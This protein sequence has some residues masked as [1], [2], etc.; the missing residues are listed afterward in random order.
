MR[1][2]PENLTKP[3]YRMDTM[4]A[5]VS[6]LR[7]SLQK[8]NIMFQLIEEFSASTLLNN[9]KSTM[10]FSFPILVFF[11][12]CVIF[13]AQFEQFDCTHSLA[14]INHQLDHV[15]FF[16]FA[17]IY[18]RCETSTLGISTKRCTGLLTKNPT[19]SIFI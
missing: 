9:G 12:Y 19:R 3:P 13:P 8:C 7:K 5:H 10:I 11:I 14:R 2:R 18:F 15:T 17:L 1:G 4:N 16:Y 6:Y